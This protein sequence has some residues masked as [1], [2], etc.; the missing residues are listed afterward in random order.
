MYRIWFFLLFAYEIHSYARMALYMSSSMKPLLFFEL[1]TDKRFSFDFF[2]D[3][4]PVEML[5][6][7]FFVATGVLSFKTLLGLATGVLSFTLLLVVSFC[8]FF[9][10]VFI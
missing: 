3:V 5:F 7:L 4:S 8:D 9:F 1:A 6:R 10:G 2:A